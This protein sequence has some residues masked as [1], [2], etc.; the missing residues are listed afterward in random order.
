MMNCPYCFDRMFYF[1]DNTG[2]FFYCD[3]CGFTKRCE[4]DDYEN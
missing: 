4:D 2:E 1:E 3:K